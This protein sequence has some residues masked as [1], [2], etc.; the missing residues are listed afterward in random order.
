M[1]QKIRV[2][3]VDDSALVRRM[4]TDVLNQHPRI[5]VVGTAQD[6]SF[7]LN[8]IKQLH[9]DVI[10]LDVEMK[11]KGGLE[12]LPEIAATSNLP[13]IM[14]SAHTERGAKTTIQALELGAID[15]RDETSSLRSRK[16]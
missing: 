9:P 14:V 7:V 11:M 4:L 6:G 1:A 16:H 5:E 13:V 12:V 15:F 3:I 2:L 8:K 10:T